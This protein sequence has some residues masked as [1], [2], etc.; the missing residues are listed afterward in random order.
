MNPTQ[1]KKW[2]EL[3]KNLRLYIIVIITMAIF[4]IAYLAILQDTLLRNS[5]ELGTALAKFFVA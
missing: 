4:G 3:F 5:Q 1:T 2:K